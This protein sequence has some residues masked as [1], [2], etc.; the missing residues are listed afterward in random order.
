MFEIALDSLAH[1][2]PDG[3]GIWCDGA[4]AMLGQ[5]RLA[6]LDLSDRG[7]QP[8][9]SSDGRYTITYNGEIYN[10]LELRDALQALGHRFASESDTEVLLAAYRQWGPDGLMRCNG[11]WAMA[12]WDKQEG[13]LFL[14]RDRFGKKPLFYAV[15]EDRLIFASEMKAIYPFLPR[16]EPSQDFAW[17]ASHIFDYE[18]TEKCLVAGIKRFPAGHH[19]WWDGKS[20]RLSRYWN[21]LDHLEDVPRRYEDQVERFRELFLDSCRIR[22]RSDV[23][24]GTALSGGLDSSATICA[25]AHIGKAHPGMRVSEDWQHAFV[26]TFPNTPFDETRYARKVVEHIGIDATFVEIDPRR[27]IGRF[28]ELFYR[29]EELYI[30]SP[31][32][33]LQAYAAVRAHG[34]RVTLDGHGADELLGGYN[35]AVVHA[36]QDCPLWRLDELRRIHNAMLPADPQFGAARLSLP[37]AIARY[38]KSQLKRLAGAT[39]VTSRDAGHPAYHGMDALGR[40]LY[41][42]FHETILPTLLRNYDRYSMANGIEIRMPLMDHR[43]VSYAFSLPSSSKLRGGFTK[44]ILRDAAAPFMPREIAYRQGKIGFNSPILDWMKGPW[45]EMFLDILETRDFR[46]CSLIDSA[47]VAREIRDVI[48]N[49]TPFRAAEQAWTDIAPYFWER[50]FRHARDAYGSR[51]APLEGMR[52]GAAH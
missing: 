3:A 4:R 21:T 23:P 18:A 24:V 48:A 11:M 15:I 20:L 33:M 2:G 12:I 43:L 47:R 1:R 19:G 9:S 6:I 31:I 46:E 25:M 7:G 44:R 37:R 34:T 39:A 17:M 36:M 5:R 30:T 50:G 28:D 32:P 41:G 8:M 22:M 14:S 49:D 45:K 10:F 26:A 42:I 51:P 29:F 27:D 38:G 35:D 16:L 40:N 13:R 52:Q